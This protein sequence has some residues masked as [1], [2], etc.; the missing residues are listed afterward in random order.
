M[1]LEY[2]ADNVFRT[3]LRFGWTGEIIAPEGSELSGPHTINIIDPNGE[4]YAGTTVN[5]PE[6]AE[7][8]LEAMARSTYV[9]DN[10]EPLYEGD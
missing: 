2:V 5:T 9:G 3:K 7:A 1:Y 8:A 4:T 10:L 6:E